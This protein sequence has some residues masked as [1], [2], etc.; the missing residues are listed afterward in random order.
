M[1]KTGIAIAVLLAVGA[2]ATGGA[3]YTGTQLEGVINEAV[4]KSNEQIAQQL[5]GMGLKLELVS[6]DRGFWSSDARYRIDLGELGEDLAASEIIVLDHIEHGPLPL[7]R[8]KRLQLVP[9]LAH[10][11]ARL[12][13]NALLE[14]LFKM[15]GG[16]DPVVAEGSIGFDR[17]TSGQVTVAPLTFIEE[18]KGSFE[19]SGFKG[20]FAATEDASEMK[21]DGNVESI[22]VKV[23]GANAATVQLKGLNIASD[24][25][26]SSS[27][28]YLG[29]GNFS[30]DSLEVSGSEIQPVVLHRIVQKDSMTQSGDKLAGTLN[31]EVGEVTYAGKTLGSTRMDWSV[32]D[33]DAVAVK[34]LMDLYNAYAVR[35]QTGLAATE[36]TDEERAQLMAAIDTLL[37][38]NPK[39]ALDNL[40]FKTANGESS[41]SL[42][43][44]LA[45]PQSLE[46][47]P[48]ELVKQLLSSLDA[49][50]V[51]AKPMISDVVGYKVLFEPDADPQ[52][53]AM[54]AKMMAEMAGEMAGAM[55]LGKLEG[56]NIVSNLNYA[57]GQVDFNGQ[58]M[59]VEQFA[60][61]LAMMAPGGMG[62][63]DD[64]MAAP[65]DSQLYYE[66]DQA[67]E[68]AEDGGYDEEGA[69]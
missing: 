9:V 49:R 48:E 35:L 56:D 4:A 17:S 45:K 50:L 39:I 62:A 32:A 14:P 55:Q 29:E 44:A 54:E 25:E 38:G 2:A 10:S 57:N 23:Q 43:L 63:P 59:P 27:G 26:R 69:E 42:K 64:S 52:A 34:S 53:V 24:R 20:D 61:M 58:V 36:P 12:E 30:L 5:P 47:P 1:K 51:V 60:G 19:F 68:E 15:S 46:L 67:E 3:W 33:L 18:G 66:E 16:V 7:S 65:D 13:Q 37:A 21:I 22:L 8:L 41:F 40:S 6:L 28:V 11:N 31:Y